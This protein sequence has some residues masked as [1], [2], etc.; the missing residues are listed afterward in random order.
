MQRLIEDVGHEKMRK[1]LALLEGL[2]NELQFNSRQMG[3]I[4]FTRGLH[5]ET[6]NMF[7]RNVQE[8]LHSVETRLFEIERMLELR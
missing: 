1:A 5:P 4:E 3:D 7:E 2:R 8:Y 6:F